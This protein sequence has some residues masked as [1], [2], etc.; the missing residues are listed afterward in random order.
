MARD[1]LIR[2]ASFE[3]ATKYWVWYY[4]LIFG[5]TVVGL[6][7]LPI[8][9]PILY[10]VTKI[11]YEHL[12]CELHERSVKV[13]RG[14]LNKREQT[15]PL[16]KITDLG[17]QQNFL[18]KHFGVEGITIETAGQSAGAMALVTLVGMRDARGF[19]DEV[20]DRRD[21]LAY[22][23]AVDGEPAARAAGQPVSAAADEA[24]QEMAGLLREIRDEV[25]G[26]RRELEQR[27]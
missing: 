16:D 15:I 11:E 2:K 22:G 21:R 8:V 3:D 25:R 27:G 1:T 13:K 20:L 4:G 26:L 19:R 10:L 18:M 5:I 24:G 9:L 6:P 14:W 7:L 12:S 23:D 17:I